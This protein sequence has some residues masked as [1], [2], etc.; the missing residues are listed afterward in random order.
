VEPDRRWR[1]GFAAALA[2]GCCFCGTGLRGVCDAPWIDLPQGQLAAIGEWNAPVLA[3]LDSLFADY[4]AIPKTDPARAEER[5][6]RLEHIAAALDRTADG[7]GNGHGCYFLKSLRDTARHKAEY[8][9][10]LLRIPGGDCTGAA[11]EADGEWDILPLCSRRR[12]DPGTGQFF[13]EY[14]LE[15]LDPCH[16]SL[17]NFYDLWRDGGGRGRPVDFFFWLEDKNLPNW[18]PHWRLLADGELARCRVTV[19]GDGL[20]RDGDGQPLRGGGNP[21]DELIFIVDR[22]G[23]LLVARGDRLV[24]HVS[25]SGGRAVLASGSLLAVDGT[26]RQIALESGHY[27][28]PRENGRQLVHLFRRLGIP[29][30]GDEIFRCYDHIGVAR[31]STLAAAFPGL[32]PSA[33]GEDQALDELGPAI[34]EDEEHQLEGQ[35]D[36]HWR[37]HH[38]SQRHEHVGDDDVHGDEGKEQEHADLEGRGQLTDREGRDED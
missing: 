34:D 20:L 35:G 2:V 10:A 25:L 32:F 33:V 21:G 24:H 38:H 8:L 5:I 7:C 11:G 3:P 1:V 37:H 14:W 19:G 17:G 29:L 31:D 12:F 28:P 16:R 30:R 36:G 27:L 13:G 18:V 6:A 22:D 23:Q 15:L 26:I 4:H 9:R